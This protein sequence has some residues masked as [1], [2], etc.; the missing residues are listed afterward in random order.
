MADPAPVA[1]QVSRSAKRFID[2]R[3]GGVVYVWPHVGD[4]AARIDGAEALETGAQPQSDAG[5]AF[6]RHEA[7][8]VAVFVGEDVKAPVETDV[9]Y[10]DYRRR[11]R[12][13]IV[14]T[15][16]ADPRPAGGL[17][18]VIGFLAWILWPFR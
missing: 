16:I 14:A 18:D 12:K 17:G 13:R 3:L 6:W 2:R 15:W 7:D 11:P 10:L 9:L 8:D 5:V 4:A 1:I